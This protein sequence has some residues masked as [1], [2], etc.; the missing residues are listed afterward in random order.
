VVSIRVLARLY[1]CLVDLGRTLQIGRGVL[2]GSLRA[3]EDIGYL[4]LT[5]TLA[6]IDPAGIDTLLLHQVSLGVHCAL[7]S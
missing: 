5:G 7:S 3:P 2:V 4:L 6:D 1:H